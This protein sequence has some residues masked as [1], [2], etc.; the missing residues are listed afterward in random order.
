V[1]DH[2]KQVLGA[3]IAAWFKHLLQTNGEELIRVISLRMQVWSFETSLRA[4]QFE[5]IL[6]EKGDSYTV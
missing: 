6:A 1:G 4:V 5:R 3:R 2:S